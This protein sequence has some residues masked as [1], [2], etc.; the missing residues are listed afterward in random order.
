M[1]YLISGKMNSGWLLYT[2]L[3]VAVP[4]GLLSLALNAQSPFDPGQFEKA[5]TIREHVQL[6]AD[7]NLYAVNEAIHFAAEH[8]V[9]GVAEGT[10]WSSV[11][12]VELVSADG[13]AVE[14]GKF[15]I[16]AG[17]ARG[18]LKI[19]PS[20]FSGDY[21]L[22]SYT[23][24][25]RNQG[26]A[27]FAFVPLKIINPFRSEVLSHDS[28]E[29]GPDT[30][31]KVS[32]QKEGLLCKTSSD[33]YG[34]GETVQIILEGH[35]PDYLNQ[36]FCC[37]TVVPEGAL[38]LRGGQYLPSSLS[39]E[40]EAFEVSFLPDLGSGVS[41]SG[42]VIDTDQNP[43]NSAT[44]HFSLLG[45]TPDYFAAISD[46]FGRFIFTAPAGLGPK[47][48]FVTPQRI[49][50]SP[51]EVRIDQEYD[52]QPLNLPKGK[53]HLSADEEALARRISLNMQLSRAFNTGSLVKKEAQPIAASGSGR[54]KDLP[55]YGSRVQQLLIDDY[56]R[57][58]NLEEV[59]INLVPD[60]QFYKKRGENRIRILSENA[61]IGVFDP[62]II[63]DHISVFD[64]EA[65]LALTPD[66]IERID[67][68]NEVY[69]KGNVAFGGVLAIY[70]K[71][72]DMAGIDLPEGSYFFDY[73][74]FYPPRQ[75][76]DQ[77]PGT[78]NPGYRDVSRIHAILTAGEA[79][80]S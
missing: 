4:L 65:V 43:V 52:S 77:S 20:A 9:E 68:I 22:K 17:R 51:L 11:L 79:T 33:V 47:E 45:D 50:G 58:P 70:S 25:M 53:F 71:K 12:Y 60:V 18:S 23:R 35:L 13:K 27:S 46:D 72:G 36:L 6:F 67:L 42:T 30:L 49:N 24:W 1:T 10:F 3:L 21:Y 15:P 78:W 38:D 31:N 16:L 14:Q 34:A 5:K 39:M 73:H 75:R 57:L 2:K 80:F 44:L 61:S 64:H 41:V 56:V 74:S 59:F 62:L 26:S 63:V 37:L 32:Y 55:F 28:K 7:R 8:R 40:E 69:L 66:K 19:P 54:G 76:P 29:I 48:L